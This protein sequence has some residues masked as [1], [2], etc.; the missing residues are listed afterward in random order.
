MT[1]LARQVFDT[2]RAQFDFP[3]PE[4]GEGNRLRKGVAYRGIPTLALESGGV[5]EYEQ[6]DEMTIRLP[7]YRFAD[8]SAIYASSHDNRWHIVEVLG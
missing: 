8:G 7:F 3:D 2:H 1:S 5:R 4:T 6:W